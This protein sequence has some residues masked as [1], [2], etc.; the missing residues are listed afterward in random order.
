MKEIKNAYKLQDLTDKEKA[1]IYFAAATD[2]H[3]WIKIYEYSRPTGQFLEGSKSTIAVNCSRWKHSAKVA[4]YFT[5]VVDTLKA[6]RDRI[7]ELGKREGF[8]VA[9]KKINGNGELAEVC[10]DKLT[11][12]KANGI[13]FTD[14]NQ[15]LKYLNQQANLITDDK[16]RTDYIKLISELARLKD[17]A[18]QT[19]DIQRFY[20]PVKCQECEIYKRQKKATEDI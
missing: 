8:E 11:Q 15:L 19:T 4:K 14:K 3:D 17:D 16:L 12:N 7:F 18:A 20:T 5:E 2:C 6:E 10:Q 1:L 13:D 9:R